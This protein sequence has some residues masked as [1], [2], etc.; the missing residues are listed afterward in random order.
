MKYL[1]LI[2]IG[3]AVVVFASNVRARQTSNAKQDAATQS[4]KS[5][6]PVIQAKSA[7]KKVGFRLTEWKTY[8]SHSEA[9]AQ[10]QISTLMKIG[11]EVK[12]ENHGNHIDVKYRC[13]ELEGAQ[14]VPRSTGKSVEHLVPGSGLGDGRRQSARDH[15]KANRAFSIASTKT[16]HL[17]D[18]NQ[19][20]QVIATLKL[21]GCEVSTNNHGDHIDATFSCPDWSTLELSTCGKAHAWQKWLDE[22]GFETE[23]SH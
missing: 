23:H 17:H 4:S 22:S 19:A 7:R 20:T 21:I 18:E 11:C 1:A 15:Q 16:V 13:G 2:T 12:S 5:K 6:V 3:V 14:A 8:H 9:E 10:Q